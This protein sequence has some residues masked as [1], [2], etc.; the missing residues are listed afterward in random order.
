MWLWLYSVCRGF[1]EGRVQSPQQGSLYRRQTT[2]GLKMQQT[3]CLLE[4]LTPLLM[5]T[6]LRMTVIASRLQK[7]TKDTKCERESDSCDKYGDQTSQLELQHDF[8]KSNM[9]DRNIHN[10]VHTKNTRCYKNTLLGT[11]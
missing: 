8:F 7:R 6:V 2:Q 3:M 1:K 4:K 5:P 9:A 11:V 10:G